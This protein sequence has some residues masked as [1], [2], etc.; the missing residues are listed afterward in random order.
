MM[1]ADWDLSKATMFLTRKLPK[2][3]FYGGIYFTM[4]NHMSSCVLESDLM[5][6]IAYRT[7]RN[8]AVEEL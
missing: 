2:A 8:A 7:P 6:S 3:G 5:R 4:H 1:R